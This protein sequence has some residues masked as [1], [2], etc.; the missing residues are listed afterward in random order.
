MP[1][2]SDSVLGGIGSAGPGFNNHR[3]RELAFFI[4][5]VLAFKQLQPGQRER[6]LREPWGFAEWLQG[7]PG[8]DARQLR[9]M[10]L[11]LLFPDEFERIFAKGDRQGVALA[12]S[13]LS[14]QA[15]NAQTALERDRT[16]RA[17]R[18]KLES[19]Y[20]KKELDYYEP[21]LRER[22]KPEGF[23]TATD[24]ITAQ[25]VRQAI[26]DIDRNGVPTDAESTGYDL[27]QS[28]HR[29]PPKL[30]LSLAAKHANGEELDRSAF[31][32]GE[33]SSAFRLLRKLGFEIERKDVIPTLIEKFLGQAEAASQLSVRGYPDAYRG[34]EVKVSF[35]KGNVARIPWI[36]FLGKGQSVSNGVYPVL[37][38][39]REE[40]V[41]LLC[42]GVSEE[43][44]P[45]QSWGELG[46][47]QRVQAC[48]RTR[49]GRNPDRYGD[50]YVRAAYELSQAVPIQDL[51]RE[52]DRLIDQYKHIT[53]TTSTRESDVEDE[54]PPPPPLPLRGPPGSGS[55]EFGLFLR[56]Y[57]GHT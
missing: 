33:D 1:W 50:S 38:L 6:L 35:G 19:D 27:I 2:L 54:V 8:A 45:A 29:Y 21:P 36:A 22:W 41:L 14:R 47:V 17:V 7:I 43:N 26:A 5:A 40:K 4:T 9:H 10:L 11:F 24:S 51:N 42:Y 31:S 46:E 30:V 39:F 28:G 49:F 34:L 25:H 44:T 32:G 53:G 52:L 3:W 48:F 20:A 12:F 13:G 37:L 15:I 16:L 55:G 56:R 18:T 23:P 57:V